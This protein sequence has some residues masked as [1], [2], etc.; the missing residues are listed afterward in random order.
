MIATIVFSSRYIMD[1]G[2]LREI[3]AFSRLGTF[4]E[5]AV[6]MHG[7]GFCFVL[8][9]FGNLSLP[10]CIHTSEFNLWELAFLHHVGPRVPTQA[11]WL[12][13]LVSLSKKYFLNR[14]FF[15]LV[16]TGWVSQAGLKPRVVSSQLSRLQ[17][18]KA[19]LKIV[20]T[21]AQWL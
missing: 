4:Y 3:S 11:V 7:W 10:V 2:I 14:T 16:G 6:C 20:G 1:N 15:L 19:R 21:V 5:C 17:A 13:F 12:V 8:V 18:Y 9:S